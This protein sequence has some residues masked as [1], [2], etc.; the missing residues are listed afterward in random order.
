MSFTKK[1]NTVLL[2]WAPLPDSNP[3]I[4]MFDKK[5]FFQTQIVAMLVSLF[6]K[7]GD[8]T[9]EKCDLLFS[10]W[11]LLPSKYCKRYYKFRYVGLAAS[12]L[13]FQFCT[14]LCD[15]GLT[16]M[17]PIFRTTL[18]QI[19]IPKTWASKKKIFWRMEEY[20]RAFKEALLFCYDTIHK[21]SNSLF[22]LHN[23]A[24]YPN[25]V[26]THKLN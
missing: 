5:H 4:N 10:F 6:S 14:G 20:V 7:K 13:L 19:Q 16:L 17:F 8:D 18:G 23:S 9:R 24:A 12:M 2:L 15:S 1:V 25:E 22:F 11:S 26:H 21:Y 3:Q